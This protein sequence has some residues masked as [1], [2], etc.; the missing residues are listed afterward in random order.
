[1]NILL[2]GGSN[3]GI[4]YGWGAQFR[5]IARRHAV[6]DGFL[7]AVGSLF[8]LLRLLELERDGEPLPDI[9]VFEYALNDMILLGA[10][11]ASPS[12]LRATLLD[13]IDFCARRGVRLV[14]LC[15]EVRP[16]EQGARIHA[17]VSR[18]ESLYRRIARAHGVRCLTLREIAGA[19]R[20]ED[21]ADEHHLTEALS[22]EVA[23]W[24]LVE[25]AYGRVTVPRPPASHRPA[26]FYERASEASTRGPCRLVD[27]ESTVFSGRFLEI[28]R[29][30]ASLW[31]GRGRLV[32][33]MLRSTRE[34]GVFRIRT[35]RQSLRKNAQSQM[36]SAVPKLMLLHYLM[37]PAPC[38]GDLEISMP[39]AEAALMAL[40]EDETPLATPSQAPFEEQRL[41]IHG[42]MFWRRP[43]LLA[44]LTDAFAPKTDREVISTVPTPDR[45]A[46]HAR[47]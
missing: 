8:G 27:I 25:I 45:E 2:V 33:L 44:R 10:G 15:L 43:S 34:A 32:A 30:G 9:V 3:T 14:F 41:E 35:G 47:R 16:T 7:G 26:L 37:R 5:A 11:C 12:L 29:G 39:E 46:S 24:L 22:K 20:Y 40:R 28:A 13:V 23:V 21:F 6:A 18:V 4:S 17:C 42:V 31:P 19:V 1:M 38:D 36:R